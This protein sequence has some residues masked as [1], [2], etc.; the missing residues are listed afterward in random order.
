MVIIIPPMH[1]K[2][3]ASRHD[4]TVGM[5]VVA[6]TMLSIAL[7][8]LIAGPLGKDPPPR[9]LGIVTAGLAVMFGFI[10]FFSWMKEQSDA[11]GSGSPDNQKEE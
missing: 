9:M 10:S 6:I 1:S 2:K 5:L 7:L 8:I 4:T 3:P 11:L